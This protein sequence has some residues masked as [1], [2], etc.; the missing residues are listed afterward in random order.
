MFIERIPNRNSPPCIL[1]RET[2][3]QAGKVKHRTIAN[4]SK[5]PPGV[6]EGLR[7]L[8]KSEQYHDTGTSSPAFRITRSLPHGHVAAVLST[9]RKLGIPHLL[10]SKPGPERDLCLAMIASRILFPGSKLATSRALGAETLASTLGQECGLPQDVDEDDLYAAMD[11]LLPRQPRIEK[12]LASRHFQEGSL[13]LYDLTSSYFEGK[14]CPLARRGYSRDGK[15]GKLQIVYGL[16]CNREG[17]PVAVEVFEGNTADPMT[18][19]A[20]I[21]K[22]RQ[23]F[24]LRHLVLV[25]DRGMLTQ[26]RIDEELRGVEGL[27]WITA[28]RSGQIAE[29]A[30]AGLIEPSLFDEKNLAEIQSPDFPD[31]R[32]VVCR[33]PLL[34]RSRAH[35]RE[36]LLA[37]TE[38]DL[39]KIAAAVHRPNRPLR[40][41]DRIGLKVG[42]L[43]DRHKMAKHF[44]LNI[45]AS[46]FT[47][48]RRTENIAREAAIDGL[49]VVRAKVQSEDF[50]ASLLVER[51]K[52]LSLVEN[53]FR[54]LKTVDLKVRPIHHRGEDRVR[55]HVFLCMLAYY[56]EWHMRAALK[57]VLFDEDAH[58][59]ARAKRSDAVAPKPPSPS[60][61]RKAETKRTPDG[62]PVHSFQTLLKDLATITRNSIVPNLPGAP[63]W[64]QETEPTP[65]QLKI[66]ELLHAHPMSS[67]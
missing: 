18:L 37:A 45:S 54:C 39:A 32:L 60:A 65:L 12:A 4:L 42:R 33:N 44:D 25:G 61:K 50:T 58:Q 17:T 67:Q 15:K 48:S 59:A 31:E 34:A 64:Q 38:A 26:A 51:Y 36:E 30:A 20:Q 66:L 3:R 9:M 6:V 47:Y 7:R 35:N 29:L 16:L 49:Y 2:Y 63:G 55:C 62:L 57:T 40:G 56:V 41:S 13:V 10:G 23:R 1:L 43:I 27:D 46:A 22:L 11:W 14:S 28:L 21:K 5:W 53:A 24:G 52:D 8:F 19:G